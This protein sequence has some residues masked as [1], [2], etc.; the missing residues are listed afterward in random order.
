[1]KSWFWHNMA[2]LLRDISN[3]FL[4][5][6]TFRYTW[7]TGIRIKNYMILSEIKARKSK[8]GE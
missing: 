5:K 8:E 7:K 3:V 2:L 6:Y 4:N 1:M